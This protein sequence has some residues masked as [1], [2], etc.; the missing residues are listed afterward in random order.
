MT[1]TAAPIR[2]L[3][4]NTIVPLSGVSFRQ[5]AVRGVVEF[6]EVRIRHDQDNAFDP[7]AC[8]VTT[9]DGRDLGFIPKE[10]A[11]RMSGPHPGGVWRARVEEVLRGDTWGLRVRIGPLLSQGT[12]DAGVRS[13]GLRHRTD[14]IVAASNGAVAVCETDPQPVE[15]PPQVPVRARSGRLLGMLLSVDGDRV[16]VLTTGGLRATYPAAVVRYTS[17][18]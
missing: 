8:A 12:R 10:L 2:P 11:P 13:G 4:L 17:A 18:A 3:P 16:H 6:D 15:A 14:G 1:T 5:D 7:N 9:L